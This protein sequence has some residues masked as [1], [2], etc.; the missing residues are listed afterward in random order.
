MDRYCIHLDAERRDHYR[1]I[2]ERTGLTTAEVMRRLLDSACRE[3][4]LND[5]FPRASGMLGVK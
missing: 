3:D 2:A 5:S 1:H 4:R